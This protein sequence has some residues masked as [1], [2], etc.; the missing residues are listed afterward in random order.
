MGEQQ[1]VQTTD[2]AQQVGQVPVLDIGPVE[3]G[4]TFCP[5]NTQA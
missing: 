5:R 1:A 4:L 2:T 3:P